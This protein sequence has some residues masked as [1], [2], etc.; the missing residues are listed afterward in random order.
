MFPLGV[1][2]WLL[3]WHVAHWHHVWVGTVCTKTRSVP[4][5]P[6]DDIICWLCD[7]KLCNPPLLYHFNCGLVY[8]ALSGVHCCLT[9]AWGRAIHAC[10]SM[11][12]RTALLCLKQAKYWFSIWKKSRICRSR[13]WQQLRRSAWLQVETLCPNCPSR[14]FSFGV[15]N[16]TPWCR[17]LFSA[18]PFHPLPQAVSVDD[19]SI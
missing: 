13:N 19:V 10:L 2:E 4:H 7:P 14:S 8:V 6:C 9:E 12:V 17:S 16:S 1:T 3:L 15:V 5:G 18:P 11:E